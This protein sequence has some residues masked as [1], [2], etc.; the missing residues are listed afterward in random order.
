[1]A[2]TVE[3]GFTTKRHNSTYQK[4]DAVYKK[5][6]ETNVVLKENTS[7]VNPVFILNVDTE[8]VTIDSK[9]TINV[10]EINYCHCTQFL[11]YYWVT[12]I[13]WISDRIAEFYCIIDVLASH[14]DTQIKPYTGY[15]KYCS[16]KDISNTELDDDRLVPD[17]PV[18]LNATRFIDAMDMDL[19]VVLVV[20]LLGAEGCRT[21]SYVMTP[22]TYNSL[23][24]ELLNP[25]TAGTNVLTYLGNKLGGIGSLVDYIVDS[26]CVPFKYDKFSGSEY[27]I[28]IAN[29]KVCNPTSG[30]PYKAKC[31]WGNNIPYET[32]CNNTL[33]ITGAS[34]TDSTSLP[35]VAGSKNDGN[36]WFLR[37]SKYLKLAIKH[38]CG[39]DEFSSDI[40]VKSAYELKLG[41]KLVV[42][43]LHAEYCIEIWSNNFNVLLCSTSGSVKVPL[44]VISGGGGTMDAVGNLFKKGMSL[45]AAGLTAGATTSSF[46]LKEK[47]GGKVTTQSGIDART[48]LDTSIT[49]TGKSKTTSTTISSP[50]TSAMIGS[51]VG[52]FGNGQKSI[53]P[54]GGGGGA[55]DSYASVLMSFLQYDGTGT[56]TL[57]DKKMFQIL[58]TLTIPSIC[59]KISSGGV[60]TSD[61]TEYVKLFG[62]PCAHF[63]S[64]SSLSIPKGNYIQFSGAS[65][66]MSSTAGKALHPEEIISLNEYLN[67]GIFFEE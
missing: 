67:T 43:Y 19:T 3:F 21:V 15:I 46:T 56:G 37:G 34:A 65:V 10:S 53:N 23:Q 40:L 66:P 8:H 36:C 14:L 62:Y 58:G 25:T 30:T 17:Y 11:R 16:W 52:N 27:D 38:P 6:F 47:S 28:I 48:G 44:G 1:M 59:A 45:A 33:A 42:D 7:V 41:Y 20:K 60:T 29:M 31:Y 9:D 18:E 64:I 50:S 55:N 24:V 32:W 4:N 49:K 57:T 35:T 5:A 12:D 54:G 63:G 26:Y 13:V 22:T 61:Y 39:C 51:A 2:F